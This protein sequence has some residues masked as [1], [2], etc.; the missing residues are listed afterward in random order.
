MVTGLRAQQRP[1]VPISRRGVLLGAAAL[2]F[3]GPAGAEVAA[4]RVAAVDWAMLETALALGVTPVAG[5]EL[6]LF[7]KAAVEPVVPADVADIG[8]RGALSY[9]ALLAARPDLILSSPWYAA[10]EAI[11]A[12]IAPV[13]SYSIYEPG[14]PPYV[15]AEAATRA[16]GERLG[17]RA[18]A[19]ALIAAA[20]AEFEAGRARLARFAT[21][22]LLIINL[23]DPRH[24]RAFGDDSMFVDAAKRLGLSS[25]W[26]A[27]T[28]FGAFP[29]VG[30]EAL[31]GKPDAFVV[32]V[33][34]SPR[35][36]LDALGSSPLW[37]AMPQIAN[38]RVVALD[39]VNAY[40]G[41]PAARRFA[42]LLVEALTAHADG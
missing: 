36:A 22:P 5:A 21:R 19:D 41:V 17:R 1:R 8:L 12:R 3:A 18:E 14:R 30:V 16:L 31:A 42:R 34:P 35:D 6:R 33:G 15:M 23:G 2:S 9:E 26:V 37:R 32:N 29:T 4:P 7:A 28:A 24:F 40:G 38:G 13:A 27:R 39:P 25:A 11:L 20:A 10:R